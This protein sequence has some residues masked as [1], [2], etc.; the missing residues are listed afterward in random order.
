MP[1]TPGHRDEYEP[2]RPGLV[3][4][5]RA[6]TALAAYYAWSA[7][8]ADEEQRRTESLSGRLKE[9]NRALRD[10]TARDERLAVARER[11]RIARE[12][13][14][15]VTQTI[16]AMTLA[17]RSL[18]LV[19]ADDRERIEGQLDRLSQLA[20]GA[21]SEMHVLIDELRPQ[22]VTAEG[23]TAA[24]RCHL[25]ARASSDGLAVELDVEGE[26]PLPA[27]EE[28]ALFRIVRRPSTTWPNTPESGRQASGEGSQPF[29]LE[30]ADRGRG[31]AKAAQ[32][33]GRGSD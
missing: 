33:A 23:L 12:L 28:Q 4:H 22:D 27:A 8:T 9:A 11:G 16:F 17:A 26:E 31:F 29:L 18:V 14:D 25:A 15:S 32:P 3:P 20:E 10:H 21:L 13:H 30:V 24:L 6:V 2:P 7:R 5:V 19:P 1:L